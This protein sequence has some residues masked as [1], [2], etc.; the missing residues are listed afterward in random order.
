MTRYRVVDILWI[1][2]VFFS[3]I[4]RQEEHRLSSAQILTSRYQS[5]AD[6]SI[7]IEI[8]SHMVNV[9]KYSRSNQHVV[10]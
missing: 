7:K 1:F 10:L 3:W 5:I 9:R 6:N 4:N 8:A 2:V